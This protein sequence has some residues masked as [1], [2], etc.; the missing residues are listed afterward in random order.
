V[1]TD[2][3]T[4]DNGL[5][6]RFVRHAALFYGALVVVA[7]VW[8][9]L[10]G[11]EMPLWGD[12]IPLGL[13][14]GTLAAGV[15]IAL[16]AIA[17]RLIPLVRRLAEELAPVIV[18][19][20]DR[21][22]LILLS[23]FSGIGEEALF[24]GAVQPEFGLVWASLLFGALHIGP[25]RRFLLWTVWAVLAGFLFGALFEL[26]GGLLAPMLAH[27]L[28]NAASFLLYKRHRGRSA[29]TGSN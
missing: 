11:R 13:L 4:P 12:S 22:A 27:T 6:P 15:T 10:R 19:P 24:R 1:P 29:K 26:T 21:A 17:Y 28:H 16:G 20:F 7:A 25:G 18:D 14:L 23:L 5:M 3:A 2:D 8:N 9:T